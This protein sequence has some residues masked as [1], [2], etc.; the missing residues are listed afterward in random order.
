[1]SEK[2][3]CLQ[4]QPADL[5]VFRR[6]DELREIVTDGYDQ[7]PFEQRV[8]AAV[9]AFAGAET[10]LSSVDIETGKITVCG[11]AKHPGWTK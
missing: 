8:L 9:A 1:V 6:L 7:T 11:I 4:L 2:R 3:A 10:S 5:E